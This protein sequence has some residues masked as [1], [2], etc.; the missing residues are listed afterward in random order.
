MTGIPS[1]TLPN[2]TKHK[3]ETARNVKLPPGSAAIVSASCWENP[4]C[5]SAQAMAVAAPT[6]SRIAPESDAVSTSMGSI[7]DQSNWRY[8]SSPTIIV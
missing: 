3:I 5:V 4:D 1:S 2:T 7:R 6:I 8:T